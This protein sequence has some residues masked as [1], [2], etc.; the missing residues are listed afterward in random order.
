MKLAAASVLEKKVCGVLATDVA[1]VSA[2]E[3]LTKNGLR[4]LV[5]ILT[6]TASSTQLLYQTVVILI[7]IF[8]GTCAVLCVV[9]CVL[10]LLIC[11]CPAHKPVADC[12][13]DDVSDRLRQVG[14]LGPLLSHVS[15][16]DSA[17]VKQL[18]VL[19]TD[20]ALNGSFSSRALVV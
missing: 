1:R 9:C 8:N 17:L 2:V 19:I 18:L 4:P 12:F 6:A 14:G 13:L 15:S 16:E 7:A 5:E 10:C 11:S 3:E 20:L